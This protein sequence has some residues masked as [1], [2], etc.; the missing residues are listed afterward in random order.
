[1]NT[2]TL[3][4][5]VEGGYSFVIEAAPGSSFVSNLALTL[6]VKNEGEEDDI[7]TIAADDITS[8]VKSATMLATKIV[9]AD[10]K[11]DVSANADAITKYGEMPD[12]DTSQLTNTVWYVTYTFFFSLSYLNKLFS[13]CAFLF[14]NFFFFF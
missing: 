9:A 7:V 13:S 1:M 3:K 4:I 11:S 2:G 10:I 12:W 6:T 14:L 5:E 8:S